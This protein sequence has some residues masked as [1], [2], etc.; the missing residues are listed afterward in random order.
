[1]K[2]LLLP[3]VLLVLP[4]SAV[5]NVRLPDVIGSSMVLQQ[6]DWVIIW[7]WAD[8]GESV[9]VSLARRKLTVVADASGKW[10]VALGKLFANATPQ[11]MTIAGKNT[12][13]LKDILVGEVWLVAGPV[14]YA[15]AASRNRKRRRRSGCGKP[16]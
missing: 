12:I 8:P 15:A 16:S 4:L 3:F 14:K 2:K 10:R 1:M 9:T 11:T 13:E 7:G 6:K 5:A